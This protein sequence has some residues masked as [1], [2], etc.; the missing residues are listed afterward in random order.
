MQHRRGRRKTRGRPAG[1]TSC[2]N[3]ITCK[4]K[5]LF[6]QILPLDPVHNTILEVVQNIIYRKTD[7]EHDGALE[8]LLDT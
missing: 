4:F 2:W 7:I 6:A 1:I 5:D 8:H 3:N